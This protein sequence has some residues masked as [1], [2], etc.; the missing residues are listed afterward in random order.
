MG[1]VEADI[2]AQLDLLQHKLDGLRLTHRDASLKFQ[3]EQHVLKRLIT[4]LADSYFPKDDEIAQHLIALKRELEQPKDVSRLIPRL[5]VIERVLKQRSSSMGKQSQLLDHQ[6]KH[7]AETLQRVTY[8]PAPLKRELRQLIEQVKDNH[9]TDLSHA[10]KLI[11]IYERSIK[12]ITTN[13]KLNFIANDALSDKLQLEALSF[14]LQSLIADLDFDGD[15]GQELMAIR[16]QLLHGVTSESLITL[17]LQVLKLL[18]KG[19]QLERQVSTNF[20]NHLNEQLAMNLKNQ[21]ALVDQ[22]QSSIEQYQELNSDLDELVSRSKQ[23]VDQSQ[24]L[25]A[26]KQSIRPLLMKIGQLSD[27]LSMAETRQQHLLERLTHNKQQ[28]E[29]IF[30]STQEQHQRVKD[31][32]QRAL[33]DPLTQVYNQTAFNERLE[34]EYR[35]WIRFQHNLRVVVLDIDNF[36]TVNEQYGYNAGD[37]ALKIIAQTIKKYLPSTACLARLNSEEFA[38]IFPEETDEHILSVTKSLQNEVKEL[39]FTFKNQQLRISLSAAS[40]AFADADTPEIILDK[41][42]LALQEGKKRGAE[43]ISWH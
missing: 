5:A 24:D 3:R 21:H 10:I 35:R 27:R 11:A 19:T 12:I 28:T 9:S 43:Q 15:I 2:Q 40:I 13:S 42:M 37:K 41:V 14:E 22:H 30:E 16:S 18:L 33:Q 26:L 39:P 17:T 38:L 34:V 6:L 31:Q 29:T 1:I 20:L 32:A 36:K 25:E 23:T 8:L 4:S 7:S